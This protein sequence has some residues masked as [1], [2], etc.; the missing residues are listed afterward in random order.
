MNSVLDTI[1]L[2]L[3]QLL[4]NEATSPSTKA[5]ALAELKKFEAA[6]SNELFKALLAAA[7]QFLT[8]KAAA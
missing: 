8:V 7:E 3:L 2:Y 6:T 1:G 4:L 5:F